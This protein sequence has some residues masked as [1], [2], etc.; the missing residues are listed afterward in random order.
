MVPC[1]KFS[2]PLGES[3]SLRVLAVAAGMR[4]RED[5]E[6]A[7]EHF[8]LNLGECGNSEELETA[9]ESLFARKPL[10]S[11]LADADKEAVLDIGFFPDDLHGAWT[12][13][14]LSV[15]T[16]E[17]LV[18]FRLRLKIS[19]YLSPDEVVF[20]GPRAERAKA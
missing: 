16:L 13:I 18:R 9:L 11:A 14:H 12:E 3:S 10:L 15:R 20:P 1:L 5:M 7:L 17:Q 6:Q 4:Q 2:L 19:V 8:N